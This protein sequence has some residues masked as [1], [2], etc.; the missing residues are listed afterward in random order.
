[1]IRIGLLGSALLCVAPACA[2]DGF[3]VEEIGL[4]TPESILH[5]AD[6][7]LYLVANI[8]GRPS[9]KDNNGF[10]SRITP[11]GKLRELKWIAG[12]VADVTLHAPKGMALV[13]DEFFVTDI[14]VVR[15]FD[16]RTGAPR[17]AI[18][19]PGAE[20][21]ND[22]AAGPDG[23]VYVTDNSADAIHK[24]AADGTVSRLASGPILSGPNG[25]AIYQS[26]VYIA[27]YGSKMIYRLTD[28]GMRGAARGVPT[29][30]LDGLVIL[31]DGY[32]L[33][34]S[35]EGRAIYGVSADGEVTTLF[36]GINA[37]ADIGFDFKRNRILIPHFMDHRIEVRP[38]QR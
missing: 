32:A 31:A 22:L 36:A 38:L 14:D 10:I 28:K 7:D 29:A 20:F 18:I 9:Q 17:R 1:M 15:V 3:L 4:A 12:G 34:S 26:A 19:I 37:P 8:N 33:V 5:D 24:I 30:R 2:G 23:T 21:L 35:W 11:D 13:A 16:R 27:P 6:A 25:I